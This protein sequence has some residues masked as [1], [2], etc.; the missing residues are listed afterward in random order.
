MLSTREVRSLAI[1]RIFPFFI[2]QIDICDLWA[3]MEKKYTLSTWRKNIDQ[4]WKTF[5]NKTNYWQKKHWNLFENAKSLFFHNFVYFGL[6][7]VKQISPL[8]GYHVEWYCGFSLD[9]TKKW[10]VVFFFS[11]CM[12][13]EMLR[14]DSCFLNQY[15]CSDKRWKTPQ[16][17]NHFIHICMYVSYIGNSWSNYN[18]MVRYMLPQSKPNLCWLFAKIWKMAEMRVCVWVEKR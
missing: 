12:K 18:S 8:N 9:S 1:K 4:K 16:N 14:E 10:N 7:T 11:T 15:Y 17:M 2:K 13:C 6:A 3:A 5:P